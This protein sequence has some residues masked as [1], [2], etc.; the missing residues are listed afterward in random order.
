MKRPKYEAV[1]FDFDGTIVDVNTF[2]NAYT[3]NFISRH[4]LKIETSPEFFYALNMDVAEIS[5]DLKKEF[6]DGYMAQEINTIVLFDN[7]TDLLVA[8]K[9]AGIKLG[10]VSGRKRAKIVQ[11]LT[12]LNVLTFFSA[13]IGPEE[14]S[15]IKPDPEPLLRC[16][17]DLNAQPENTLY[18]GN[19]KDDIEAG[20]AAKVDTI[21]FIDNE[22][23]YSRV[24]VWL[25]KNKTTKVIQNYLQL[26]TILG[27]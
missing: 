15:K 10:I 23:Y 8:M 4:D 3:K 27:V 6:W 7:L 26:H 16:M 13:I 1:L 21:F 22:T 5:Y 9:N 24:K 19:N 14:V 18:I 17:T 12:R 2:I 25:E 20:N 11:I